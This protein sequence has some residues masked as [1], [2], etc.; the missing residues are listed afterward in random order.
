LGQQVE[1]PTC[2]EQFWPAKILSPLLSPKSTGTVATQSKSAA[3]KLESHLSRTV[4]TKAV[5]NEAVEKTLEIIG[6]V[7]FIAGIIG[8]AIAGVALLVT[9]AGGIE[10]DDKTSII[11]GTICFAIISIAQGF[12]VKILFR[13]LAE[14]IR[15][16]RKIVDKK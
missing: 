10:T 15:L 12:I 14:I 8:A 1:C 13:A 5:K 7:F 9:L 16:L 6:Q 11:I 3:T 4:V 2:N